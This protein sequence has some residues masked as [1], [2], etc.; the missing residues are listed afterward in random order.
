MMAASCNDD[1]SVYQGLVQEGEPV[2]FTLDF[3]VGNLQDKSI[4]SRG[5][6]NSDV[7]DIY[8]FIFEAV[9]QNGEKVPGKLKS[10]Q[11]FESVT[12]QTD[13][14]SSD[15][16]PSISS[17]KG[18]L[19]IKTTQGESFIYAFANIKTG[20]APTEY[21]VSSLFSDLEAL[22]VGTD[23]FSTLNGLSVAYRSGQKYLSRISD[24][25]LMAG[26]FLIP[27]ANGK[28]T[29]ENTPCTITSTGIIET[30]GRLRF[31]RLDAI[32][33][34]NISLA[35]DAP[36]GTTFTPTSYRIVNLPTNSRLMTWTEDVPSTNATYVNTEKSDEITMSGTN[37]KFSFYMF[38]NR[39]IPRE[40]PTSTWLYK[41]REQTI[42]DYNFEE[43]P[44]FTYAP[45]YSTYVEIEGKFSGY[46]KHAFDGTSTSTTN[47]YVVSATTKYR[48]HLGDLKKGFN[49]FNTLRNYEYTY[50][51]KVKGID[52]IIVEVQTKTSLEDAA[53]GAI[54]EVLYQQSANNFEIDSH[55]EVRQFTVTKSE[56]SDWDKDTSNPSS[57]FSYVV[58]TC[59]GTFTGDYND[60]NQTGLAKD[61]YW[62]EFLQNDNTNKAYQAYPGK[63]NANLKN[64]AQLLKQLKDWKDNSNI[65]NDATLTFDVFIDE[66]YYT[67][68]KISKFDSNKKKGTHNWKNFCNK[69]DRVMYI[70]QKR[71]NSSVSP[72]SITKSICFLSQKSIQTIYNT[73]ANLTGLTS[74]WGTETYNETNPM[75]KDASDA[76]IT[77]TMTPPTEA[78]NGYANQLNLW[79]S[80]G[81]NQWSNYITNGDTH[82]N[83]M[84]NMVSV[85]SCLQRNRDEDGDGTIDNEEKKWY[86]PSVNQYGDLYIGE[87]GLSAESRL[88]YGGSM[89]EWTYVK[90][91][92]ASTYSS[93]KLAARVL[94][95]EG[96]AYN[97]DAESA[98]DDNTTDNDKAEIFE[99]RCLRNLGS[100][101]DNGGTTTY[102]QSYVQK[103]ENRIIDLSYLNNKGYRSYS[104]G[105]LAAEHFHTSDANKLY[106]KYQY[107]ASNIE[108]T[109]EDKK[110]RADEVAYGSRTVQTTDTPARAYTEG[111][112]TNWRAMN[113]REL[114]ILHFN[115]PEIFKQ[116]GSYYMSRTIFQWGEM[117][118]KRSWIPT[119]KNSDESNWHTG[120]DKDRPYYQWAKEGKDPRKNVTDKTGPSF[121]RYIFATISNGLAFGLNSRDDFLDANL[122]GL[123][124][125]VRDVNE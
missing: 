120:G 5:G 54:G 56:L 82:E 60:A 92:I 115:V 25:Y 39:E 123:I 45:T 114:M 2:E 75:S 79:N 76:V 31:Y 116:S 41:H 99:I 97:F 46:T 125:P 6:T 93:G 117:R 100:D 38:E 15:N 59:Y 21:N 73:D 89:E 44:S 58:E 66:Y 122:H 27:D 36:A 35:T 121:Y 86:L 18:E 34:F 119:L 40:N 80:L 7:K 64:V 118:A 101:Y 83:R 77:T 103:L 26:L 113:Q 16:G 9:D 111:G 42:K 95:E 63:G 52:D 33:N 22:S 65:A 8:L 43:F 102:P 107:A 4:E 1:V 30:T 11:Y 84:K 91:Y 47:N 98:Y 74:A 53:P 78:Q 90:H 72:S 124:R 88:Y 71:K 109:R 96:F 57:D 20:D 23:C 51:I 50:N 12:T 106:K 29:R 37:Y 87:A 94:A 112:H 48:V 69:P 3:S 17:T 10:K 13:N 108:S 81:V 104:D 49:D 110:H 24:K 62:V 32:V 70:G 68:D 28:Y 14:V 85:Y 19:E 105:E 67:D 61:I 55:F